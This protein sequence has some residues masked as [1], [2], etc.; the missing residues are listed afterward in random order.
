MRVIGL[1]IVLLLVPAVPHAQQPTPNPLAACQLS[2]ARASRQ[3]GD[4]TRRNIGR[5][6]A[7]GLR[8]L[9]GTG[10]DEGACC[11]AAAPRCAAQAIRL[12]RAEQ[13]FAGRVRVG[14]CAAVPFS[15]ILDPSGLGFSTAADA[16]RCLAVPTEVTDLYS[17]AICLAQLV[18]GQTTRLLALAETPRAVDALACVGLDGIIDSLQTSVAV[19]ACGQAGA[20]PDITPTIAGT[21]PSPTA[22]PTAM[23]TATPVIGATRTVSPVPTRTPT[24]H[25]TL[26]PTPTPTATAVCGN[27]IVEDDEECDGT[28][29]DDSGCLEDVCTCDDFC[30]DAGGRLSCK[31]DCTIDFSKCTAGGCEF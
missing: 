27:G 14:R 26:V 5:C 18:D 24:P 4:A 10:S 23:V 21:T 30:D 28:A 6:I 15:T 22:R 7:T 17:L 8:C 29:F 9:T 2:L 1:A 19:V 3:L 16:C 25:R 11:A 31:R 12:A 20:T 13:R